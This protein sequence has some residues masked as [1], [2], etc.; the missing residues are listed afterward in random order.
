MKITE[1]DLATSH[2]NTFSRV[3]AELS[4]QGLYF[5]EESKAL[6]LLS[7][8]PPSWEVFCTSFANN[9]PKLTLDEA[10]KTILSEDIRHRSMGLTVDDN[11][12]AHFLA[13]TA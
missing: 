3:L 7:S 6:A 5:E 10:I 13:E 8:L 12:E 2:I 4:L 1:T 9:S 11:A